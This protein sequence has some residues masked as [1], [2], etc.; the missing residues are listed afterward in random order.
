[1]FILKPDKFQ[2]QTMCQSSCVIQTDSMAQPLKFEYV[3]SQHN[4]KNSEKGHKLLKDSEN[5]FYSKVSS[6]KNGKVKFFICLFASIRTFFNK[7]N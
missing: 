4:P 7:D 5:H 6:G 1:M 3:A 2:Q